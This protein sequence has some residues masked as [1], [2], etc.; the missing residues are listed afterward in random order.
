M[1]PKPKSIGRAGFGAALG[2]EEWKISQEV[3]TKG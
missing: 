3:G 2:L 1:S